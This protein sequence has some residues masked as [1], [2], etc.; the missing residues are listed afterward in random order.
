MYTTV[1]HNLG[2][3]ARLRRS[4]GRGKPRVR[5][6]LLAGIATVATL[7]LVPAVASA[8]YAPVASN[9]PNSSIA[10][11]VSSDFLVLDVKDGSTA[12]GASVIQWFNTGASNQ[13]WN[14][15]PDRN[16]YSHIQNVNSGL[17]LATN[18]VPG[19]AITQWP[20]S[21]STQEDWRPTL[22]VTNQWF[23]PES[24]MY[25]SVNGGSPWP[26]AQLI[27]WYGNGVDSAEIFDITMH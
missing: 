5:R 10:T 8:S 14:V 6:G 15:V 13:R 3:G 25:L 12:V 22:P 21:N 16:G 20:C 4:R 26:G 18:G 2:N 11:D 27:A 17:C 9:F 19:N 24:G 23:N 7:A 1:T